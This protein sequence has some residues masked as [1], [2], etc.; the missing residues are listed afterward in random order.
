MKK[1]I[2]VVLCVIIFVSVFSVYGYADSGFLLYKQGTTGILYS[3]GVW[4][5]TIIDG[6]AFYYPVNS[7]FKL[8][9]DLNSDDTKALITIKDSRG[10]WSKDTYVSVDI[11]YFYPDHVRIAESVA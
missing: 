10:N 4:A 9:A 6:N 2:S 3:S 1:L 8:S 5:D 11:L 7:M